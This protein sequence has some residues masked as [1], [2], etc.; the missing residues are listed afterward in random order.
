MAEEAVPSAYFSHDNVAAAWYLAGCSVVPIRPD[1]QKR[2]YMAWSGLQQHRATADEVRMW[3]QG[4]YSD[5]GVAV[6]CGKVSENLEMLELEG[7]AYNQENLLL[8]TTACYEAGVGDLWTLL[9]NGGYAETTPAGGLHLLYRITDHQ[10][11]PNERVASRPALPE[12]YTDQEQSLA[13]K[14]GNWVPLRVLAE[15][16]GEGGY[17]IV[18]PSSGR[19]HPS[20]KPWVSLKGN[21]GTML[22]ISWAQ[23]CLI[24]QAIRSALHVATSHDLAVVPEER[25]AQVERD[26]DAP[27]S[28]VEDFNERA[29][30]HDDWFVGQGWTVHHQGANG[31]IFWCRPGKDPSEQHAASTG[32]RVG[33][34][35]CLYVWSTS[36]SLN[37]ETPLTKFMVYAHYL[38]NDNYSAA[39]KHLQRNGYGPA[40]HPPAPPLR[41][42]SLELGGDDGPPGEEPGELPERH[43]EAHDLDVIRRDLTGGKAL[44]DDGY[45]LRM[46]DQYRSL[47]RYNTST[48]TWFSWNRGVGKWEEDKYSYV[49]AAAERLCEQTYNWVRGFADANAGE[50]E[51]EKSINAL[52]RRAQDGLNQ[53][54]ISAVVQRFRGTEGVSAAGEDFD[55]TPD[56][57]NLRNGT[58]SLQSFELREHNPDDMLTCSFN[59]NYNPGADCSNFKKYLDEVFPD[60]EVQQYIQRCLGYS[61]CGRPGERALFLLHGPSGTGKSVFIEVMSNLFGDYGVTSPSTTFKQKKQESTF[62]LHQLKGK[63]FVAASELPEGMQLDEELIKRITG[64]D[65]I[66][67]RALYQGFIEWVPQCVL[68]LATNFLPRLSGDDDAIWRR[69]RTIPMRQVIRHGSSEIKGLGGILS[70]EGDGILNWL[71]DGLREYR[72]LG[73]LAEPAAILTDVE[74]YRTDT[75]TVASWL[76]YATLEG[77]YVLNPEGT[78]QLNMAYGHY[79][80]YC[81]DNGITKYGKQRFQKKLS[82]LHGIRIDTRLGQRIITGL[83]QAKRGL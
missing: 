12:E 15:T 54:R 59:A 49:E 42:F 37:T 25:A 26:P 74:T 46:R 23:R 34:Q 10:V 41:E 60:V 78:L 33:G 80:S 13:E 28:P 73:G 1:G 76:N 22:S 43:I 4:M 48:K 55:A 9:L 65:R 69:V 47:L 44:T 3:F 29:S 21:P 24:H 57:L 61:L 52:V 50:R 8:I 14:N 79:D 56:L 58:L 75:D 27:L 66:P 53:N 19:C 31:E 36:T 70:Q 82:S 11:P 18:A 81:V 62:D 68:W 39:A 17:V 32:V 16:R 6:I 40:L 71:L 67:S 63:R 2:P 83:E 35:D 64:G 30:W 5:P 7:R 45:A 72:R 20:G 77:A 51:L 38:F